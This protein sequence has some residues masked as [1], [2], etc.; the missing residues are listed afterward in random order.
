[1]NEFKVRK[2]LVINGSGSALLDVQGSVGQLTTITDSLSG[3]LFSI[4]DISGIPVMEAFSDGRIKI[5]AFGNEAI[6]ISGSFATTT[7]SL[8]GTASYATN[9]L[10]ASNALSSSYSLSSSFAFL[11]NTASYV[12]TSSY[13]ISASYADNFNA[14]YA[15]VF[16]QV[17]PSVTWSFTHNLNS[18][19][20]LVQVY[21]LAYNQL[22]PATIVNT[23]LSGSSIYFANAQAG[24]A[25]ISTGGITVTGSNAILSQTTPATTW[26][27][28][29]NLNTQYPVFTVFDSSN[30]VMMPLQ[31][32]ATNASSASI[33]FSTPQTG[34]VVAANGGVGASASNNATASFTN[35]STWTFNH[36]L[37]RQN[38]IIQTYDASYNKI[39]PQNIQLTS[40]NTAVITFPVNTSGFAI[41]SIGGVT[42]QAVTASYAFTSSYLLPL[43][44]SVIITGSLTVSGSGTFN[45]IGPANF[46]GSVF[47]S[48]SSAFTGS[49]AVSGSLNVGTNAT[50]AKLT[51]YLF[52]GATASLGDNIV[53]GVGTDGA[54]VGAYT[55]IGIGYN[56]NNA[57]NY[58]PTII[59]SVIEN[60][61]GQNAEAIIFATRTTPTGTVR[62]TEKVRITS[63]GSVGIGISN[64]TYTLDVSGS[65]RSTSTV[66]MSSPFTL[67]NRAHNGDMRIDQ[68]YS[69]ALLSNTGNA[70]L[71]DRY[72]VYNS[73]GA[74][75]WSF[76]RSTIAPSGFAYSLAMSSS[77]GSSIGAG[78]YSSI[79]H[80]IEANNTIDLAWGTSSAKPITVQFWVKSSLTGN[81]GFAVRNGNANN[82]GYVASYNIPV[83]NTWTYITFTI[84]GPT[85]GTWVTDNTPGLVCIWDLGAGTSYSIA[86]GSWTSA[87]EIIGLTGGV[88]LFANNSA[89]FYLTGV[90]LEIGSVATPFE[91][92]PMDAALKQCQRY[93]QTFGSTATWVAGSSVTTGGA[94]DYFRLFASTLPGGPMR[95]VPTAAV[96]N[97][98]AYFF[99]ATGGGSTVSTDIGTVQTSSYS[100]A[101]FSATTTG[102]GRL[103]LAPFSSLSYNGAAPVRGSMYGANADSIW[104]S[105]EI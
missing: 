78:A 20:P 57:G 36:N 9:A 48:G 49:I 40:I 38:V 26:S 22:I 97:T 80:T 24:Y 105:A 28:Y 8:Q 71:A 11:A 79:R 92:L 89:N 12:A 98:N 66:V 34:T 4:N 16:A 37:N 82:Y 46:T 88:K 7:G 51:S 101:A 58:Y 18:F 14:G 96:G 64:P 19:V 100:L 5:G 21:D 93:F 99:G 47:V 104:L 44:Q 31:I 65:I 32:N 35:S 85:S 10:S 75:T 63:S 25:V 102:V 45:N 29:H 95:D 91:Y 103:S 53:L 39:I 56:N 67:R 73:N 13:A 90:Q 77:V 15:R 52:G 76:Q 27:F 69:G 2:G 68:K 1:M 41:A 3:S 62:P 23:S 42:G 86:A 43:S 59:G 72:I 87:S 60:S 94:N 74:G 61:A 55:Q 70:W 33:Y 83:A 54:G 30:N 81:F 84:P 6:K 50:P 17:S